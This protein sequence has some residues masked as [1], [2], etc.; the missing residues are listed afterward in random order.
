MRHGATGGDVAQSRR[1]AG[2]VIVAPQY[3]HDVEPCAIRERRAFLHDEPRPDDDRASRSH[4]I[5]S[6]TSEPSSVDDDD[7]DDENETSISIPTKRE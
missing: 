2:G 5:L 4:G 7:D 6:A 3:E 1:S